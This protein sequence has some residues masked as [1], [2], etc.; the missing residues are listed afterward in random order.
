MRPTPSRKLLKARKTARDGFSS[1]H[2][3]K[4]RRWR[5]VSVTP[6]A[7]S[8]DPS[9][10]EFSTLFFTTKAV[11]KGT[12]QGLAIA[13]SVIVEKHGGTLKFETQLNVGTTFIIELPLSEKD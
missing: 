8:P 9:N 1:A 10:I 3:L 11:G 2:A 5:S 7:A 6:A 12:G 13:H 4:R